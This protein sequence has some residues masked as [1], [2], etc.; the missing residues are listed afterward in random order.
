MPTSNQYCD[1]LVPPVHWNVTVDDVNVDD[2]GG[3]VICAAAGVI[4][5]P[6]L[7]DAEYV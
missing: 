5:P 1:T 6:P 3:V 4:D 2:G 7:D